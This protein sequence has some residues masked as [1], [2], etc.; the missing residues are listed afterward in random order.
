[1]EDNRKKIEKLETDM[2]PKEFCAMC[3]SLL[4]LKK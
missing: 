3:K 1:M 2:V 4:E